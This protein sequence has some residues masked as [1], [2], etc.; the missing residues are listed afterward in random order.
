MSAAAEITGVVIKVLGLFSKV[1]YEEGYVNCVLRGK[2][3]RNRE[4]EKYSSPVA[5][6]DIV[7]FELQQ[8]GTGAIHEIMPRKNVFSRKE[9]GRNSREDVI[10]ANLDQ[11]VVIQSY[12][13]PRLNLR[14][15]DRLSIRGEKEQIP[16]LL[17]VN[18]KDL[19]KKE[20]IRYVKSY[21]KGA[22]IIIVSMSALTG[23]GV[24]N[25]TRH[26]KGKASLFAGYS[27]VGKTSIL[28]CMYPDLDLRVSEVSESTGKGRH[29]TTNVE[30]IRAPGGTSI[31]D[32]PGLREFGLMD[33]EP[34]MTGYF[35]YEFGALGEFCAFKPCTH[36]HEPGC[37]VRKR[38]EAGEIHPDRYVSYLNILDSIRRSHETKYE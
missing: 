10:A 13:N 33:I 36:D 12:K 24:G 1:A 15:V 29:T 31:I 2:M 7:R 26:I 34:H 28:K 38:V 35:F 25:F 16:V 30:M 32:T 37:E 22:P 17:C 9:K 3:R 8:D 18:K 27:G 20:M 21:Y 6:G 14:F 23:D 19:V 4:M 11:I 5:V